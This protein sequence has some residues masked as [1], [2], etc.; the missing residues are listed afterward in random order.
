MARHDYI[1]SVQAPTAQAEKNL[2]RL[3]GRL[4]GMSGA[5][6]KGAASAGQ[7]STAFLGLG[8][9]LVGTATT[10]AFVGGA[11]ETAMFRSRVAIESV[12]ASAE[13]LME[14]FHAAG[15]SATELLPVAAKFARFR[16]AGDQL[17]GV[18]EIARKMGRVLDMS[19]QEAAAA[20]GEIGAKAG[21]KTTQQFNQLASGI[22]AAGRI[23]K[24]FATSSIDVLRAVSPLASKVGVNAGALIGF[25]VAAQR[26]GVG[27]DAT[28]TALT[29]MLESFRF[30]PE[31]A[32]GM[33]QSLGMNTDQVGKFMAADPTD[34]LQ[35]MV[36]SMKNLTGS[37][38]ENALV[39]QTL[40]GI[41]RTEADAM[42]T[43]AQDTDAVNA[44]MMDF[45][46]EVRD[47][48]ALSKS[49]AEKGR[50]L[51]EAMHNL[52]DS[53]KALGEGTGKW[54]SPILTGLIDM[55]STVIG[56]VGKI[57]AP[58]RAVT[59]AILGLVGGVWALSRAIGAIRGISNL[60]TAAEVIAGGKGAVG[61]AAAAGRWGIIGR[62]FGA[63][64]TAA[65]GLI[66]VL[67]GIAS[68]VWGA[69]APLLPFIAIGALVVA[70]VAAIGYVVYRVTKGIAEHWGDIT[71]AAA[72]WWTEFKGGLGIIGEFF[73]SLY[74]G[75]AA[76][77]S[78]FVGWVSSA[79]GAVWDFAAAIYGGAVAAVKT[80]WSWVTTAAGAV[81]GLATS[82]YGGIV[83][84]IKT[85]WNLVV[86]A[87]DAI[88]SPFR[89][90][91][92]LI[93]PISDGIGSVVG[94]LFG[95]SMFH[96]NEGVA[97]VMP[98]LRRMEGAFNSVGRAAGRVA[99]EGPIPEDMRV[100]VEEPM[101]RIGAGRFSGLSESAE[102]RQAFGGPA[103][104]GPGREER[105]SI[106]R[107]AAGAGGGGAGGMVRVVVPVTLKLDGETIARA[108]SEYEVTVGRE[109]HMNA[110]AEP[111]RATGR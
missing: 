32:A 45:R 65:L 54:L 71:A 69:I 19:S 41:T 110:P 56:W 3:G 16:V 58:I 7:L 105:V 97:E 92:D 4:L 91:W 74:D 111:L 104:S 20:L 108:V 47:G 1:I 82:I 107:P 43:M 49:A 84:G 57:P 14:S 8:S 42:L 66:P 78:A 50:T 87:G 9:T 85:L 26:A 28:K 102:G 37:A 6:G 109:R 98:S 79:A 40:F 11:V 22:A 68:A 67:G 86:S 96:L 80:L 53:I 10:V 52:W 21:L 38:K 106:G 76:G 12:G 24:E 99:I 25:N 63:V 90:L 44:T 23:E 95:S 51:S 27:A 72:Q 18:T 75:I 93:S 83:G 5:V 36:L 64:R 62:V 101:G 88:L 34:Q 103:G 60:L 89:K 13:K 46:R 73:V 33:A 59:V 39:L 77:G 2:L 48:T 17:E 81:W 100:R 94:A 55:L 35:M 30:G 31:A 70:A 15:R 61:A 29:A